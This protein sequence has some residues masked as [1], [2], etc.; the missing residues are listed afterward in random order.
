MEVLLGGKLDVLR[1]DLPELPE[2]DNLFAPE[3]GSPPARAVH[4]LSR[5]CPFV[6]DVEFV[7]H[8]SRDRTC[9]TKRVAWGSYKLEYGKMRRDAENRATA[10]EHAYVSL[11]GAIQGPIRDAERLAADA[12]GASKTW[13]LANGR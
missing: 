5:M 8:S 13:L 11:S 9:R 2:L 7:Y 3:V 1:H 6:R 10:F 4:G 12:F